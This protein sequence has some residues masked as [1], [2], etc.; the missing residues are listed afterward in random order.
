MFIY[1]FFPSIAWGSHRF[2]R[3]M[4][5]FMAKKLL[6]LSVVAL[7][8]GLAFVTGLVN[9]Q[10]MVDLYVVLPL[11]AVFLGLFLVFKSFEKEV[12]IYDAEQLAHPALRAETV[13]T[14]EQCGG[15][16]HGH[17]KSASAH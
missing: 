1:L 8:I 9:A 15:S 16:T 2:I 4:T 13:A 7:V 6:I 5:N 12:S 17:G 3:D 11:G 14:R 10:A